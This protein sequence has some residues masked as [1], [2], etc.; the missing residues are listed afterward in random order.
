MVLSTN[1]PILSTLTLIRTTAIGYGVVHNFCIVDD[2][3]ISNEVLAG[4]LWDVKGEVGAE[5]VGNC[6]W[7]LSFRKPISRLSHICRMYVN[8][9]FFSL[10]LYIISTEHRLGHHYN[11][12]PALIVQDFKVLNHCL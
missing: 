10:L 4:T 1:L 6:G 11:C 2:W 8:L 12:F 3:F 5:G 7:N 9:Q